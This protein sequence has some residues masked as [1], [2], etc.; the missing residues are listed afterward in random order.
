MSP[1]GLIHRFECLFYEYKP[2]IKHNTKNYLNFAKGA[3]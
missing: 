1:K 2:T 3:L